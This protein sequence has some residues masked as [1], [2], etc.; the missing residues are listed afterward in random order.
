[1][2]PA[3]KKGKSTFAVQVHALPGAVSGRW[4]TAPASLVRP[5]TGQ[6]SQKSHAR[7]GAGTKKKGEDQKSIPGRGPRSGRRGNTGRYT[8]ADDMGEGKQKSSETLERENDPAT[9][10]KK[11]KNIQIPGEKG[12]VREKNVFEETDQGAPRP[13]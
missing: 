13:I 10:A 11:T 5:A 2:T 4:F 8:F 1:M 12:L 3:H 9:Q 7:G 6:T